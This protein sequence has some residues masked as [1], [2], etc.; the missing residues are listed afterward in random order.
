[1][2]A[3]VLGKV[4]RHLR[5]VGL[6]QGGA[7]VP[8]GELLRRHT[9]QR[10][11]AAFEALVRRHGPMV[12]GVCR[13]VLGNYHDAEDAFQAT[14]L[15]L[16]RK[17]GTLRSPESLGNWL[18]GVAHRT[19]L[20]AHRAA[21]RRRAKEARV[22]PRVES[23][24]DCDADLRPVLDQEL[25]RL[26]G[27]YRA[28]V[29]LCDLEGKSRREAAQELRCAEGTVA[30]RLAR[31]RV[32]LARR[33]TRH[34]LRFS[35]A[36]LATALA[37][38]AAPACLPAPLV[39]AT[40]VAARGPVSGGVAGLAEGVL[41][42]MLLTKLKTVVGVSL[43]LGGVALGLGWLC[44]E[45]L[46]ATAPSGAVHQGAASAHPREPVARLRGEATAVGKASPEDTK[47][48]KEEVRRLQ[49]TWVLAAVQNAGEK[50]AEQ[51]VTTEARRL[52]IITG[53][54]FVEGQQ[55]SPKK[56]TG[57]VSID[58]TS[59]P[60]KLDLRHKDGLAA[61]GIYE[62]QD[63]RL[64]I[65]GG[66]TTPAERP[67]EMKAFGLVGSIGYWKRISVPPGVS[68]KDD[69]QRLQGTWRVV[70]KV[71]DGTTF[72]EDRPEVKQARVNLTFDERF[73]TL[74]I[75]DTV[76]ATKG[77]DPERQL[78]VFSLDPEK[79]PKRILLTWRGQRGK[80]GTP[81]AGIYAV[82]GDILQICLSADGRRP[83]TDFTAERG[84]GR[85][86]YALR[87]QGAAD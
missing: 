9:R 85:T 45:T 41:K 52:L 42:A 22:T 72:T 33:L 13:R 4:L 39:T 82:E 5:S 18:Y 8:D 36:P 87:R 68:P 54:W 19:A 51:D 31:G 62:L 47:A 25:A 66:A 70:S 29:V 10:D 3:G 12:L 60:K 17:A 61:F 73:G 59:R 80:P 2:A 23:P 48:V 63:D 56:G 53:T 74:V 38:G 84:S 71:M 83:P 21:M 16:V 40:V 11:E 35:G 6:R 76:R 75:F 64:T 77:G 58:P 32:L 86:L 15:V 26:P 14:F 27:K 55:F 81:T 57:V 79:N 46:S 7:D 30:S 67:K 78:A 28:A 49:G 65:L 43:L 34:G 24:A 20:E 50:P 1:M 37:E 69:R 44:R